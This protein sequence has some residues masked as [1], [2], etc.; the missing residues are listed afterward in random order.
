M[1]TVVMMA[2]SGGDGGVVVC[3]VGDT[4]RGGGVTAKC[5]QHDPE[6]KLHRSDGGRT[7]R[8]REKE[9]GEGEATHMSVS[10]S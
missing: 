8:E 2:G 7:A 5:G 3:S 9:R 4:Q 10:S 1:I 6:K